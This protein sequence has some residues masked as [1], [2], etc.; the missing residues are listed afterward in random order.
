MGESEFSYSLKYNTH[1]IVRN[2]TGQPNSMLHLAGDNPA[3][4]PPYRSSAFYTSPKKIV[5][6]FQYPINPGGTRDL[7][8]IPGV[9]ESDIRASLLKG[10]LRHKFLCGDIELISSNIDLLQFSDKQ[11]AWLQSYGFT[12]GVTVGYDELD[13]YVQG[14]FGSGGGGGGIT[15]FEHETLRHLIH[16]VDNGPGDR[17]G[18]TL[19]RETLPHNSPFP[20]NVTWYLDVSKTKKI[21][22]KIIT[23]T[24]H[25]FPDTILWN[26]YGTDGV[27]IVESLTDNFTY[28]GPFEISRTRVINL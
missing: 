18:A 27:T 21:I 17:F 28:N 4:P 22:E 11:R 2:I 26:M 3:I 24:I 20:T 6:I 10:E 16:F 8:Q 13:G 7:L 1:F 9:Q 15:P 25:K 12:E 5:N 19:F 23:Y 14:L